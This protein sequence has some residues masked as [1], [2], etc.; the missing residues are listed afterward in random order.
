MKVLLRVSSL[1]HDTYLT[2][3]VFREDAPKRISSEE[4]VFH[5]SDDYPSEGTLRRLHDKAMEEASRRGF[6]LRLS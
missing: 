1:A 2:Y 3:C 6:T 5:V 4:I